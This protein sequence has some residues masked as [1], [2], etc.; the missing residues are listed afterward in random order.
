VQA[1]ATGEDRTI[2]GQ[3][4]DG[5]ASLPGRKTAETERAAE[6]IMEAIEVH[7]E[8]T[9]QLEEHRAQVG[10][11]QMHLRLIRK[12]ENRYVCPTVRLGNVFNQ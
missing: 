12:N 2:A 11:S 10:P 8:Q 7:E 3:K 1:L 9:K 5:E 6:R 4:A